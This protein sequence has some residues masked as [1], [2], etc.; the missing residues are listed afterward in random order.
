MVGDASALGSAFTFT[1]ANA[2]ATVLSHRMGAF[3]LNGWR[4]AIGSAIYL[5][6]LTALGDWGTL[7][8]MPLAS[9]LGFIGSTAIGI[10]PGDILLIMSL[11]RI[12]I[13][14]AMPISTTY[15]VFATLMAVLFL[16]EAIS[17]GLIVAMPLVLAGAWLLA[18]PHHSEGQ[19]Q[20]TRE[21]RTG[22]QP[23]WMGASMALGAAILWAVGASTL[24]PALQDANLVAGN[25]LR[26]VTMTLLTL[27]MGGM[28]QSISELRQLEDR[29]RWL[30]VA[31]GVIQNGLSSFLFVFAI[32]QA[33]VARTSV[34]SAT[35]P[36]FAVPFGLALLGERLTR[37]RVLGAILCALGAAAV[38]Y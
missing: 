20:P 23:S 7:L 22:S 31:S 10:V 3:P 33:G 37:A 8:Q 11:R 13:S 15:P 1:F 36:L 26:M 24:K 19:A 4:A 25:F 35:S 18:R 2:I 17:L 30:L 14:R 6:V 12:G 16:R 9:L 21:A 28:R 5:V 27:G 38:F 29:D 34:L 32:Q